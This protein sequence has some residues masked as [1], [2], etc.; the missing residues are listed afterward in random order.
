V[1]T[2]IIYVSVQQGNTKKVASAM[3]DVLNAQLLE[4]EEVDIDTLSE[5]D[6]IGL[7]S[8]IYWGRFYKRLRNFVKK[9]PTFQNMKV[10]IFSTVGV[11]GHEK[12]PSKSIEK[13]LIKKGFNIAGKFSCLGFN[14]FFLSR[15]LGR[16]NEGRPDTEDLERAREFARGLKEKYEAG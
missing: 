7:G 8:G 9:I 13:L 10:F 12:S 16:V 2:L 11:S 1:K 5:Y 15:I 4:P 3:A 6:L 14:T